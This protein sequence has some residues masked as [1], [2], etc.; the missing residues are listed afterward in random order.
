MGDF[1][2]MNISDLVAAL[3]ASVKEALCA[4]GHL[5]ENPRCGCNV[6]LDLG[7][8]ARSQ[9]MLRRRQWRCPLFSISG[10]PWFKQNSSKPC[11]ATTK[12]PWKFFQKRCARL[13][14]LA[15]SL[16]RDLPS[17]IK[18]PIWFEDNVD[19]LDIG[20]GVPVVF[21]LA[22]WSKFGEAF[23]MSRLSIG[24]SSGSLQVH[25][26]LALGGSS[27]CNKSCWR[28]ESAPG[29]A[30][31]LEMKSGIIVR[32]SDLSFTLDTEAPALRETSKPSPSLDSPFRCSSA[33]T[34]LSNTFQ[35]C[36][37]WTA[38]N[39]TQHM[40]GLW[41]LVPSR[42]FAVVFLVAF[43]RFQKHAKTKPETW[44]CH[45]CPCRPCMQSFLL[46]QSQWRHRPKPPCL[47]QPWPS[48]PYYPS[49]NDVAPCANRDPCICTWDGPVF[50]FRNIT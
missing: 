9:N 7:R 38:G 17:V 21:L 5:K 49:A 37:C 8:G 24:G 12:E 45:T 36:D 6:Y 2:D 19:I 31:H 3:Q 32:Q 39:T 4:F 25:G 23:L 30:A 20:F 43:V 22:T 33:A 47:L 42:P 34:I 26:H 11:L 41:L 28:I 18:E 29:V 35:L 14:R 1:A 48:A 10:C 13:G 44:P 40:C 15:S 27:C 50:A 46:S 16:I